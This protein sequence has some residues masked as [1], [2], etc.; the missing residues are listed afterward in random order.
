M[1]DNL[2]IIPYFKRVK[3]K[4]NST[5]KGQKREKERIVELYIR[6][7]VPIIK[8]TRQEQV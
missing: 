6:G 4:D 2:I 1:Q 3:T 7:K 5:S 8:R